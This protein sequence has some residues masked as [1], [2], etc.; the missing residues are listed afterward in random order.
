MADTTHE[1][2]PPSFTATTAAPLSP[3]ALAAAAAGL[4]EEAARGPG[5]V[6]EAKSFAEAARVFAEAE[7]PRAPP[8]HRGPHGEG[9]GARR[10]GRPAPSEMDFHADVGDEGWRSRR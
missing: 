1:P 10:R 5:L 7:Q 9:V 3:N 6:D 4:A 8:P 2:S